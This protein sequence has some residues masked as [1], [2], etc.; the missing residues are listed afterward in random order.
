[1]RSTLDTSIV[2]RAV[3]AERASDCPKWRG[4]RGGCCC[5]EGRTSIYMSALSFR[6]VPHDLSFCA[7]HQS[8][9][10]LCARKM[11]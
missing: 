6:Y 10:G 7:R 2:G 9:L 4:G 5:A 11:A 8:R 1:M 3:H